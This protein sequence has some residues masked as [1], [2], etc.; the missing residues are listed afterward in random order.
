MYW[1]FSSVFGT[2]VHPLTGT[3]TGTWERETGE[4]RGDGNSYSARP[5]G[6]WTACIM[7]AIDLEL[8]LEGRGWGQERP[9]LV[10]NFDSEMQEW[11]DQ[12]QD[13]QRKIE[14]V[15]ISLQ[16]IP[17][18]PLSSQGGLWFSKYAVQAVEYFYQT[19]AHKRLWLY[20]H[21]K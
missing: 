3:T 17:V 14:E 15:I 5:E 18:S 20:D 19:M 7:A 2:S 21:F 10:D 4:G 6:Y 16:I 1:F 9:E 8:G 13:I 12:L 11:E